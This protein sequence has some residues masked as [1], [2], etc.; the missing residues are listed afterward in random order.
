VELKDATAGRLWAREREALKA[1]YRA[2]DIYQATVRP[3]VREDNDD[4]RRIYEYQKSLQD[5]LLRALG[6]ANDALGR[7]WRREL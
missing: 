5:S 2:A 1:L 3:M 6:G 7:D 4:A